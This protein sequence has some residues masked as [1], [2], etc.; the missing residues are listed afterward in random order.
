MIVSKIPVSHR[1]THHLWLVNLA[2]HYQ[3]NDIVGKMITEG[4]I[5]PENLFNQALSGSANQWEN[6]KFLL[7]TYRNK[8]PRTSTEID[9]LKLIIP[10]LL[11]AAVTANN[12]EIVTDIIETYVPI[13]LEDTPLVITRGPGPGAQEDNQ[14]PLSLLLGIALNNNNAHMVVRLLNYSSSLTSEGASVDKVKM[15]TTALYNAIGKNNAQMVERL[16]NYSSELISEPTSVNRVI[17]FT[18]A[19]KIAIGNN[20]APMVAQLL[21]YS[22]QLMSGHTSVDK[23]G[24]FNT[25]LGVQ[26]L[27]SA[28]LEALQE[29]ETFK[30]KPQDLNSN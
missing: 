12:I 27:D 16:L 13:F 24:I 14:S 10:R 20:N 15:F 23:V 17:F 4:L 22:S 18:S 26:N 2:L 6:V 19:L 21:N 25:A 11:E 30:L 28:I 8:L 29:S 9:E 1:I 3:R 7:E 5:G